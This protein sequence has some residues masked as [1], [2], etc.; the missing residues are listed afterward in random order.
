LERLLAGVDLPPVDLAL[1][2]VGLLDGGVE[3][4]H[5]GL[6]DVAA[7]A[8]AL[9]EGDDRVVRDLELAVASTW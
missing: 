4:A 1:A 7:G 9:D 2:A 5:G 3:H 8:V 6:P